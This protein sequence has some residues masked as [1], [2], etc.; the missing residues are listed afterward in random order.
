MLRG[1]WLTERNRKLAKIANKLSSFGKLTMWPSK[2]WSFLLACGPYWPILHPNDVSVHLIA[3]W[4]WS[5]SPRIFAN[6]YLYTVL[7]NMCICADARTC[8]TSSQAVHDFDPLHFEEANERGPGHHSLCCTRGTSIVETQRISKVACS[9]SVS[10]WSWILVYVN[11]VCPFFRSWK[12]D[13][14][15]AL[16]ICGV[17]EWLSTCCWL[18][19]WPSLEVFEKSLSCFDSCYLR[20]GEM[21]F[22]GACDV[23]VASAVMKGSYSWKASHRFRICKEGRDFVDSWDAGDCGFKLREAWRSFCLW[24]ILVRQ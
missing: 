16:A 12:K 4:T 5:D 7:P 11:D 8:A 2:N 13:T 23:D 18:S 24:E 20:T 9:L 21:P 15:V 19:H 22:Q 14:L 10:L 3:P 6:L 17:W 1:R